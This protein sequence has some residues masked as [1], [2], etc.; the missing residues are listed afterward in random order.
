MNNARKHSGSQRLSLTVGR[1]ITEVVVTAEDFGCGFDREKIGGGGFGLVSMRER[2][3]LVGG[4]CAV[5]S[6]PG[7]GT[8]VTIN[9]PLTQGVNAV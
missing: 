8:K 6:T 3:R 9:L 1:G 4:N 7:Q 5:E 2:S